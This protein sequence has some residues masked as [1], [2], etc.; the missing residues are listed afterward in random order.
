[1]TTPPPTEDFE[2]EAKGRSP[3]LIV[4][5]VIAA[6]IVL[7]LL[8]AAFGGGQAQPTPEPTGVP[9]EVAESSDASAN[10]STAADHRCWDGGTT[11][12]STG[13][14][15]FQLDGSDVALMEA[16]GQNLGVTVNFKDYASTV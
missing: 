10:V 1:M 11:P 7:A 4:G 8:W 2:G 3:W 12:S 5:G 13:N 16:I 9:T 15:Q 6:V 14:D